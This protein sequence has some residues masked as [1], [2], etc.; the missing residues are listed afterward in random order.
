MN[1]LTLGHAGFQNIFWCGQLLFLLQ[2]QQGLMSEIAMLLRFDS[3][4]Y[5]P[6]V[7]GV[8]HMCG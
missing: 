1:L 3:A 5:Q 7:T 8:H 4:G 6:A 2:F